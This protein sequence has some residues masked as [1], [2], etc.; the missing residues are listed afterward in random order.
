MSVCP[1]VG[2]PLHN[3]VLVKYSIIALLRT[4]LLS[5]RHAELIY[6]KSDRCTVSRSELSATFKHQTLRCSCFT[7]VSRVNVTSSKNR[8]Q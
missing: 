1:I 8:C 5:E 3:T 7:Q 4:T 2:G 6:A